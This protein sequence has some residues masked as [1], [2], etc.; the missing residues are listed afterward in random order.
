MKVIGR[1]D[2]GRFHSCLARAGMKNDAALLFPANAQVA[3]L[4]FSNWIIGLSY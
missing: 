3:F 1:R 2:I 4:W